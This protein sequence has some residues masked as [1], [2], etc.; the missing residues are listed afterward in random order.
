[1]GKF[2]VKPQI[3]Y[4]NDDYFVIKFS[5]LEERDQVLYFVPHMVNNRPI[6]MK[7]WSAYFNLHDEV[8]K[9]VLLWVRFPNLPLNC[10]SM[11]SLSKIGSALGNPVYADE[12]T[13]GSIRISYA[14]MLIEMDVTK[15]LPRI[16]KLQDPKGKTILQ[17]I[18]YDWEPAFCA[19]C[20]KIGHDCNE[21]KAPQPQ[22]MIYQ[23]KVNKG[24][25]VWLRTDRDGSNDKKQ[26][27]EQ[28]KKNEAVQTSEQGEKTKDNEKQGKEDGWITVQPKL[29]KMR[30]KTW[31]ET[32]DSN[33]CEMINK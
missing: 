29:N 31:L 24:K 6:I 22:R 27:A 17:G 32:M 9:T 3:Y 12:C 7:A 5:N 13:T 25:Q 10:W 30:S 11:K 8:L 19:K 4:Y 33:L 16:V 20:L 2:S 21:V 15:P 18:T 1:M 28:S 14:R 23:R 26:E